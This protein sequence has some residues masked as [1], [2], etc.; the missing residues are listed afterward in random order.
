MAARRYSQRQSSK[1][2]SPWYCSMCKLGST[3]RL[4]TLGHAAPL[5]FGHCISGEL[6]S[7]SRASCPIGL[8]STPWPRNWARDISWEVC[9]RSRA[10]PRKRPGSTPN[11]SRGLRHCTRIERGGIVRHNIMCLFFMFLGGCRVMQFAVCMSVAC[12]LLHLVSF[13]VRVWWVVAT[14]PLLIVTCM[15]LIVWWCWL[16]VFCLS[17]V[18][19][20][21]CVLLLVYLLLVLLVCLLCVVVCWRSGSC[22]LPCVGCW[23]CWL[24][25]LFASCWQC[26]WFTCSMLLACI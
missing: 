6:C 12:C 5:Q 24:L 21:V 11:H 4:R 16:L 14:W 1:Q 23:C 7:R 17:I 3:P 25:L 13:C 8:G 19:S 22:L 26:W 10:S 9:S 2:Y 20:C 15:L 18:A